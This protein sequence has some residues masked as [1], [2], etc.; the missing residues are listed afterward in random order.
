[1]RPAFRCLG[2]AGISLIFMLG[3]V[4]PSHAAGIVFGTV[5]D[6]SGAP[7]PDIEVM[8]SP[9][10]NPSLR[11]YR[12]KP[13]G[14]GKYFMNVENGEYH[15]GIDSEAFVV[16][17]LRI[18]AT[19]SRRDEVFNWS[20]KIVPERPPITIGVSSGYR[21]DVDITVADASVVRQERATGRL[22]G[23]GQAIESGELDR[24]S[25]ELERYLDE[26][27]GDPLG[28][29]LR[30]YIRSEQGDYEAAEADLNAALERQ[31]DMADARY[32]IGIVY[33]KTDRPAKALEAF[34]AVASGDAP[35]EL[36]GKAWLSIG[37]IRRQ[38]SKDDEA[39][40]AYEQ[41]VASSPALTAE[42]GTELA[43]MYAERGNTKKADEWLSR[44]G[45]QGAVDPQAEFNIAVSHFN[46]KEWDQ[47]IAGFRKVIA[48]DPTMAEAYRNLGWVLQV[49]GDNEGA[50]KNLRKYL[51]LEPDAA[52]A[53]EVKTT[54]KAIGG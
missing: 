37:E 47:A 12:T 10:D 20:G 36:K 18:R 45:A 49:T 27:P 22:A 1:M 8:V 50:I 23:I 48:A 5:V 17:Q 54:L 30:G 15:I 52:D 16:D 53:D 46:H 25:A 39:I 21:I 4:L 28:L 24:A 40:Q 43:N 41:A 51:E 7:Q 44:V 29:M 2:L 11:T 33:R 14:K 31:P 13:D 6:R 34:R 35:A 32:Q 9:K 26:M 38:Q 3:G 42:V 19:N